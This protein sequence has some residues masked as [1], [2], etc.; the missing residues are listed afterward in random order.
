M[1]D[2]DLDFDCAG[3]FSKLAERCDGRKALAVGVCA[4]AVVGVAAVAAH[5]V[6]HVRAIGAYRRERRA[7]RAARSWE[8]TVEGAL[9]GA[10]VITDATRFALAYEAAGIES[11]EPP[12]APEPP[13]ASDSSEASEPPESPEPPESARGADRALIDAT[14]VPGCYAILR[15]GDPGDDLLAYRDAYVG[16]GCDM[17]DGAY[18]QLCGQGNLLVAADYAAAQRLEIAFFDCEAYQ[19]DAYRERLID[20]FSADE[21]YNRTEISRAARAGR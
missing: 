2:F 15:L 5:A 11:A 10:S 18:S 21:S 1:R 3:Q 17:A 13:E 4:A 14:S 7:R 8:S 20:A 19:V 9:C 6:F 16:G 12:E